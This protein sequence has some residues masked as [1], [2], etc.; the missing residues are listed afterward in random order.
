MKFPLDM[1]AFY[2]T[3]SFF[4]YF[5]III[6]YIFLE[7]LLYTVFITTLFSGNYII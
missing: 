6:V 5:I 2:D 3:N 7:T 1:Y 4:Y